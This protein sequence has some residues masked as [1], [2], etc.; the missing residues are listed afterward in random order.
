VTVH[1]LAAGPGDPG[2]WTVRAERLLAGASAVV[3]DAE[4]A[5]DVRALAP[6]ARIAPVAGAS[7][8]VPVLL[9]RAGAGDR[10]V[11][12]AR[13]DRLVWEAGGLEAAALAAAGLSFTVVPAVVAAF[14]HPAVGGIPV[15]TRHD[16]ATL[17]VAIGTAEPAIGGG[18][19][20]VL[21]GPED[22]TPAVSGT[23]ALLDLTAPSPGVRI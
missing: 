16:A 3:C 5:G 18:T 20:V 21:D 10:V 13:G 2:L 15:M 9:E 22:V 14:A 17:T 8:A 4:L 6:E 11:R 23:V 1:L 19:I 7:E 12:M